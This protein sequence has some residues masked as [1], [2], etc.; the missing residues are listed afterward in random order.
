MIINL[1][2]IFLT[3]LIGIFFSR[4]NSNQINNDRNRKRYIKY[5]CFILI[6][7]SGL[8]NVAV[9]DDTYAYFRGFEKIKNTSWSEIYNNVINYYQLSIGK[10][11][12]YEA[13]VKCIQ[14]INE[15]YQVF[16]FI[17]ALMFFGALGNFIYKNTTRLNDVIIAFVIYSVLFYSFYSV[18]GIR[19]TIATAAS[20]YAFEFVK[21]KKMLHFLIIILLAS[22]MH[23][24]VL[25][26][27]P[28]YFLAQIK[29][30]NLIYKG[31]LLLIPFLFVFRNV[32]GQY[33]IVLGDYDQY[34]IVASS[35]PYT[36]TLMYLLIAVVAFLRKKII[37]ENNSNAHYYYVAFSLVLFFLPLAWIN[38]NA[39]RI[40]MYFSI[41]ILLFIPEIIYSFQV[42]STK[43]RKEIIKFVIVLLIVL[44][45][46]SNWGNSQPYGF[47]WE[48]MSLLEQ[49]DNYDLY[50]Y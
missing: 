5:I 45:V 11:P 35:E 48:D 6:L 2:V 20:L 10:D 43:V 22:T 39:I 21:R 17:V 7:Q 24:S 16:L 9:G 8:R 41:F 47:F 30:V 4:G 36:L 25:V 13:F 18:T 32:L 15:E 3:I 34:E 31:V 29:N 33:L 46:K 12:G 38:Q 40:G 50:Y 26:F 27:I 44:Y 37:F 1:L 19:Q 49:Y 14:I 28:F 23:K 42:V